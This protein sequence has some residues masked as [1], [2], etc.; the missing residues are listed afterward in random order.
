MITTKTTTSKG[1]F[2]II[3][4]AFLGFELSISLK[5]GVLVIDGRFP[6]LI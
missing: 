3:G 4:L 2:V 1:R 6:K 5:K